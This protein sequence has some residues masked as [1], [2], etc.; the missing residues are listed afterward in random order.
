MHSLVQVLK[1]SWSQL[2]AHAAR[3]LAALAT[4]NSLETLD[5]SWSGVDESGAVALG[6]AL[7]ANRKLNDLDLSHNNV[8]PWGA[9]AAANGLEHNETLS[10]CDLSSNPLGAQGI[11][12]LLAKG[13]RNDREL[14]LHQAAP[15][16]GNEQRPMFD[17]TEP[18]GHYKL[19]LDR[20]YD[21]W[22]LERSIELS[23][24]PPQTTAAGGGSS[25]HP[26]SPSTDRSTEKEKVPRATRRAYNLIVGGESLPDEALQAALVEESSPLAGGGMLA[27]W[28]GQSSVD[29]DHVAHPLMLVTMN[30]D[31]SNIRDRSVATRLQARMCSEP[32]DAWLNCLHSGLPMPT[33]T[34]DAAY[35]LPDSGVIE[36]TYALGKVEPLPEPLHGHAFDLDLELPWEWWQASALLDLAHDGFVIFC[37]NSHTLP[38]PCMPRLACV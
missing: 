10:R 5:L 22:L 21:R 3:L 34:R 7:R 36:I 11:A 32:S 16:L 33:F 13:S 31:L 18:G 24:Q 35:A 26:L 12:V 20:P 9:V 27:T 25:S 4:N 15:A 23:K 2:Q 29:V 38:P 30:L 1:L 6:P 14:L 8:G 19:D 28:H 37:Q 17:E